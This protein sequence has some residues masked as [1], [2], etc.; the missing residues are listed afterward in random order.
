MPLIEGHS[1]HELIFHEDVCREINLT[2]KQK[3]SIVIQ[4]SQAVSYLHHGI[5]VIV[6]GDLKP[7]NIM[8]NKF[9]EV[10]VSDFGL[11]KI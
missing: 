6:H 4:F 5:R 8:I 9:L 2:A 1:L 7:K 3:D 10:K 11:S